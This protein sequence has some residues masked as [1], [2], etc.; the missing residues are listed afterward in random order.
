MT[1]PSGFD[2]TRLDSTLRAAERVAELLAAE[3]VPA[4]VIGAVAL[5]VHHYPRATRD[6]DLAIATPP[7]S[8]PRLAELLRNQG[9]EVQLREA[10]AD[11]PLGGVVD[12]RGPGIDLVQ[13]VN[14]DN[15]PAGGFPRLVTDALPRATPLGVGP[16]R[17]ADVPALVAFKLYAGGRKSHLDILELLERNTVDRADLTHVCA[18]LGLTEELNRVLALA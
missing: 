9:Y 8:L 18:R 3:G 11:D 1:A 12:I 13:L 15:Q 10:D 4:L 17:V 5:A 7:R 14:F 2:P 16:L 6:L